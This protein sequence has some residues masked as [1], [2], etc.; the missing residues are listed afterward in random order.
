M[1]VLS[2]SVFG[3]TFSM[4]GSE[5]SLFSYI[6]IPFT[7]HLQE[8]IDFQL[9]QWPSM[10]LYLPQATCPIRHSEQQLTLFEQNSL[11]L[12]FSL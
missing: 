5:Y 9:M 1:G 10:T 3:K 11:H 4:T 7:K 2:P 12:Q 6:N 8:S